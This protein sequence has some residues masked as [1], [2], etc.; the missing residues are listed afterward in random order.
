MT[1]LESDHVWQDRFEKVSNSIYHLANLFDNR[2]LYFEF[3]SNYVKTRDVKILHLLHTD[4]AH[5]FLGRLKERHPK[6][7]IIITMFN[8]RVDH[9]PKI[10]DVKTAILLQTTAQ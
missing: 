10:N 4:I 7:K 3:I 1:G 8:S 5:E 2:E 9:F 6:L